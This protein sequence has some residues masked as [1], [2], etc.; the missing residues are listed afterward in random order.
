MTELLA[1]FLGV[2]RDST[3]LDTAITLSRRL[4]RGRPGRAHAESRSARV[5]PGESKAGIEPDAGFSFAPT[6]PPKPP[7]YPAVKKGVTRGRK[8]PATVDPLDLLTTT[9]RPAPVFRQTLALSPPKA[10]TG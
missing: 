6:T 9:T 7:T 10:G 1:R 3:R 2:Q 5:A 8:L 4:R